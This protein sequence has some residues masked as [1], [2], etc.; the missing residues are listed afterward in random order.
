[1]RRRKGR[2]IDGILVLDKLIGLSS[3]RALQRSKGIYEAQKAGHTGNLDPLATGV[4]PICFGE[5]TKFSQYLL[6]ADK[7]YE[8]TIKLG[9]QTT[10]GDVEGEVLETSDTSHIQLADIQAILP[11]FLGQI[12]QVP[13]MYSA[14]KVDG[15]PLYKLARQDIVIER[16]SRE[17]TIN[18]LSLDAFRAGEFAEIDITV[19]CS[20]GTYIRT[21]GEDIAKALGDLGGHLTRLHR[22]QS[23]QFTMAQSIS[24]EQLN[25]LKDSEGFAALDGLLIA[26]EE[27]VNHLP[28]VEI[29]EKAGYHVQLGQA[30]PVANTTIVGMTRIRQENGVFL[31]IGEVNQQGTL[32]PRRLLA[33]VKTLASL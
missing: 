2:A 3:N 22:T 15:Q 14:L 30:V 28:V 18:S 6:D 13:P 27:A 8:A 20:K 17:V 12:E 26:P 21:L 33:N 11:Q 31:G 29:T 25:S 32:A 23:G 1:M 16:K 5:A 7:T 9:V 19:S 24:L 4:L 10:T